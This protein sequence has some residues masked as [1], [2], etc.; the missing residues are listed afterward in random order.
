MWLNTKGNVP[1]KPMDKSQTKGLRQMVE[2]LWQMVEAKSAGEKSKC[3]KENPSPVLWRRCC[4]T[5]QKHTHAYTHTNIRIINKTTVVCLNVM[6]FLHS[7][8]NW[9]TGRRNDGPEQSNCTHTHTQQQ[10]VKRK[11]WQAKK[12][13]AS[14]SSSSHIKLPT[15]THGALIKL[16][17]RLVVQTQQNLLYTS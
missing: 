9:A 3:I 14:S 7:W 11:I 15:K 8:R 1:L 12:T 13:T 17:N 4:M 2:A 5:I 16:P 6:N 10:A